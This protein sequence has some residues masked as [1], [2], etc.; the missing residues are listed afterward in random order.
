MI[1][2]NRLIVIQLAE[3]GDNANMDPKQSEFV[4]HFIS[5][6]H[7][8]SKNLSF[9]NFNLLVSLWFMILKNV[10]S[11]SEYNE[12]SDKF[13]KMLQYKMPHKN[14]IY[15]LLHSSSSRWFFWTIL[16]NQ[17]INVITEVIQ[18]QNMKLRLV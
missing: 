14:M 5:N 3:V 18:T 17:R 16:P 7:I 8:I 15:P 11:F 12:S 10:L 2:K 9:L 6:N 13:W 1:P 4:K